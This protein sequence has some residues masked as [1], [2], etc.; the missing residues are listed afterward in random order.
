M[1]HPGAALSSGVPDFW[2]LPGSRVD[3]AGKG[4]LL[5][6]LLCAFKDPDCFIQ[7]LKVLLCSDE[8]FQHCIIELQSTVIQGSQSNTSGTLSH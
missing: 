3:A 2:K 7:N 6:W 1:I 5:H 8:A 4:S